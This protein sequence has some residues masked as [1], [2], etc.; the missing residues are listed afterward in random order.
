MIKSG[1]LVVFR[2]YLTSVRSV[3]VPVR[4][5]AFKPSTMTTSVLLING[6]GTFSVMLPTA[7]CVLDWH[8]NTS[9][10]ALQHRHASERVHT[11]AGTT[12]TRGKGIITWIAGW[13]R[14]C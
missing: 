7:Y 12:W 14:Q 5:S 2:E 1:K 4:F 8:V 10:S 3:L 9:A 6:V 13:R 11:V